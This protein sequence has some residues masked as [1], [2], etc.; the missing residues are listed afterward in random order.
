M[1]IINLFDQITQDDIEPEQD[2][3]DDNNQTIQNDVNYFQSLQDDGVPESIQVDNTQ[4]IEL[5]SSISINNYKIRRLYIIL[6]CYNLYL[7]INL[8]ILIIK[9]IIILDLKKTI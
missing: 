7:L 8:F 5:N 6:N 2:N 4:L 3:N 1:S 9:L